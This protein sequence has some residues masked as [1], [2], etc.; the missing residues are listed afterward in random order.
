M[1]SMRPTILNL[2]A[3]HLKTH[4]GRKQVDTEW[5]W[6]KVTWMNQKHMKDTSEM[7]VCY[8][9]GVMVV[10]ING[11][12]LRIKGCFLF[13]L[14][15][16]QNCWYLPALA[17][18]DGDVLGQL[19]LKTDE[20]VIGHLLQIICISFTALRIL[21]NWMYYRGRRADTL[22]GRQERSKKHKMSQPFKHATLKKK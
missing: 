5:L 9:Y 15:L 19:K 13:H 11:G 7:P 18:K 12:K 10:G 4:M 14:V 2:W 6:H 8:Q 17:H 20:Y 3:S 22:E 16:L 21:Q 1:G